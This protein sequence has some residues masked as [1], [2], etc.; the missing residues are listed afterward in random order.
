MPDVNERIRMTLGN[1]LV[2]NAALAAQ[3]EALQA[4]INYLEA[5]VAT[6]GQ[7]LPDLTGDPS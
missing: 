2:E 6:K 5:Q 4:R 1:L 7:S 3:I